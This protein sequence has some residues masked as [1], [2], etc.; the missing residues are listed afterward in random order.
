LGRDH[1][2]LRQ[3]SSNFVGV[4]DLSPSQMSYGSH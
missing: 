2:P 4:V 1:R 3:V